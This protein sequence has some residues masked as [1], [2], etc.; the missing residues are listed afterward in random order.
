[1]RFPADLG[2]VTVMDA[3]PNEPRPLPPGNIHFDGEHLSVEG[4][5]LEPGIYA[6]PGG[7]H[8]EVMSPDD[9]LDPEP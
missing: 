9:E 6:I 5:I 4:Q 2:T 8:L 7:G 3:D 1:M